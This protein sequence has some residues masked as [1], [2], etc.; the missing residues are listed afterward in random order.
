V[1]VILG[2]GIALTAALVV[3]HGTTRSERR[4]LAILSGLGLGV[5]LLAVIAIYIVATQVHGE[6]VWLS[7]EASY[8]LA[9]ESL[10]PVPWDN[11]LPQGLDHLAGSG[12]LGLTTIISQMLGVVDAQ[13]FRVANA[14]LGTLVVLLC[15]WLGQSFFG[16][17]AGLLAGLA[18]AVWPDLVFWS[19]T[20]LRD[21]LGSFVVVAVWW[22]L[23][24][25]HRERWLTTTCFVFLGLVVLVTLRA[26][27]AAAVAAGVGVWLVYPFLSR[28]RRRIILLAVLV[29]AALGLIVGTSLGRQIDTVTHELLYRQTVTRMETLGRL[30]RDPAP[31]DDQ[32]QLPFR[33][34][35][36]IAL[37]DP[38]T[39]WLLPGLVQ[40]SSET[41]VVTVGL[42]NDTSRTVP[43]DA[44]LVLLQDARIPPLQVFNWFTPSL[45]AVFVGLPTTSEPP[46]PAWIGAA[47]VWDALLVVGLVGL[48]RGGLHVRDW[49]YPL[50]VIGG[51]I[52]ALSAIPG[53]P[54]NAERHRATQ[55]VPLLLVL[56]SG[57]LASRGRLAS[58]A[59]P[60]TTRPNSMPSSA[61]TAV[62]SSRQSLP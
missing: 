25:A 54:G 32:I 55:T 26:Y 42:T 8:F 30:Y 23:R 33:P 19:A 14:S 11:A 1:I 57:V 46:N 43:L 56:A 39:G 51:T 60:A 6:G 5:R 2:I 10:M 44:N 36:A 61:T 24:T 17:D 45:L 3:R 21:T 35:T 27:L 9:T 40:D 48:R 50:C 34:G 7:D 31:T 58:V 37:V 15:V 38:A 62:A 53:A 41:G 47:L 13:A 49:L 12:F 28:L 20:M 16:R 4:S 59:Q 22:A 29:V 18:A 52:A